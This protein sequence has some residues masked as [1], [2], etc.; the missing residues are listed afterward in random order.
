[1]DLRLFDPNVFELNRLTMGNPDVRRSAADLRSLDGTWEFLL[2]PS[3]TAA[4]EGWQT[5]GGGFGELEVPGVWTRQHVGDEPQ[6]TNVQMPWPGQPPEVPAANPTGLH[7]TT[8]E[9]A[10]PGRRCVLTVGAAEAVAVVWCN[11]DF[12]GLGKDSRLES[13]FDLTPHVVSG[14]NTLAIMVPRWAEATWIEDQDHWFHGG[15]HRSVTV[16][17]TPHVHLADVAVD[18]DWD[19]TTGDGTLCVTVS[20]DASA[21]IPAGHVV[22]LTDHAGG[23]HR[24]DVEPDPGPEDGVPEVA[25]GHP[26]RQVFFTVPAPAVR[27]WSADDPNL[28]PY[29]VALDP[30]SDS[31]QTCDGRVGF[32]RVE[33]LD[34]QLLVN[35]RPL[36]INGVNR[37]DHHPD[38]GKTLTA[39]EIRAELVTMK[40]HNVNAVRTSHYP[41]DPVVLD[42]CDE[43]GLY[44]V[45][46]ANVE[47]HARHDTLL[48]SGMFDAAVLDRIQRMVLRDRSHP[49]VIGWSLGNE[50]GHGAVHDASAAW[51]RRTDASRFVQYEG[52]FNPTFGERGSR[53]AREQ[54]PTASDRL[55]TDVVCPMYASVESIVSWAEWAESSGADDRPLILCEY[56]HAMGNSNGGLIDYWTAFRSQRALSG[57]FVWD[58]RD[59][60]LREHT[61][62]GR[63][64]WAY[65]GHHGDG[66]HDSNFCINGLVDPD[67]DPHPALAELAWL[68]QPVSVT[69]TAAD[70]TAVVENRRHDRSLDEYTLAWHH[71]HD[72]ALVAEGELDVTGLGAGERRTVELPETDTS[73]AGL[74]TLTVVSMLAEDTGWATSGHAVAHDQLVLRDDVA[75]AASSGGPS[76]LV[77][78]ILESTELRLWRPPTDNDR[79]A[80]GGREGR[81][82]GRLWLKWGL[83]RLELVEDTTSTE[84]ETTTRTR[85]HRGA[86]GEIVRHRTVARVVPGGVDVEETVDVPAAW[87]DLARVGVSALVPAA[88]AALR[89]A[90]LGPDESY[91][92]RRSSQRMGVWAST[93]SAQY[94]AFVVPQ[95][96]GHHTDTRWF[97]LAADDGRRLR[98]DFET[99]LGFS[100]LDH[101][102]AALTEAM[103]LSEL[104]R[105]DHVEVHIDAAMRGLGTAACGP[106]TTEEHR[107]GPGEHTF[108]WRLREC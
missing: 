25:Y 83:D 53:A 48:P 81:G 37:H 106:D 101:T 45:D 73:A 69:F 67:G 58:W 107:V 51:V 104:E 82:V 16:H 22:E 79:Y 38:T 39:E 21:P 3:P 9:W 30:G 85:T 4:P 102:E 103:V 26:G 40:R 2:V 27:P 41:N 76:S 105:S 61:E 60:G 97:E 72:G 17:G 35:G 56:S 70:T 6:Y 49:C 63:M 91:P 33:I 75:E 65:G 88:F 78:A 24:A 64:W 5:G 54:A 34:R 92:D 14:T 10:D 7:R 55:V 68:A 43:L 29:R 1:M 93:V 95:E 28:Y 13:A 89:W 96:H 99:P 86:D 19:P 46:E 77:D 42:L 31:P 100:A 50:A 18:G 8:F 108:R 23:T 66:P 87:T 59:Q 12:V 71:H 57:G 62:D 80:E 47:A 32:R 20:L 90:G 36:L 84:G 98:F 52:G 15:I 74:H 44:V 11:G 94:H